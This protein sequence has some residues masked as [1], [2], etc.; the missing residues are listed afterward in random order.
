M[1]D[2]C[3]YCFAPLGESGECVRCGYEN[4]LCDIPVRWLSP[5]TVLKGRYIVGRTLSSSETEIT[6][7]AWDLVRE[8]TVALTEFFPL[9][10]VTRDITHSEDVVTVP[11]CEEAVEAG[12]QAFFEKAKGHNGCSGREEQAAAE[13]FFLRNNT[14]YYVLRR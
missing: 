6:Y 2:R 5:G 12:R 11:G 14:C 10:N 13:D 8:T 1:F 7:L 3:I 9:G 4:G